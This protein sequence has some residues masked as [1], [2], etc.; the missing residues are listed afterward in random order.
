LALS[1]RVALVE[2]G[3]LSL[4]ARGVGARLAGAVVLGAR[5]RV[6][7]GPSLVGRHAVTGAAGGVADLGRAGVRVLD[8]GHG[9]RA[10][11]AGALPPDAVVHGPG[12]V[13]V[14]RRGADGSTP[15]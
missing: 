9:L 14:P 11:R 5:G 2:R 8:A 4:C 13:V 15:S 6:V 1:G 10:A 3:T 7:A 12:V